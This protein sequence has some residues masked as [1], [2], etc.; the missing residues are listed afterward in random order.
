MKR[1]GLDDD[2]AIILSLHFTGMGLEAISLHLKRP[3]KD[4]RI[5]F[6]RIMKAYEDSG[7]VVDD[8]VFTDDPFQYY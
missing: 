7:I 1:L 6:D 8:S 2:D 3:L 5:A 4:I